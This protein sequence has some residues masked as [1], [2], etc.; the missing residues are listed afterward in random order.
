MIKIYILRYLFAFLFIFTACTGNKNAFKEID[1][2]EAIKMLLSANPDDKGFIIF[3]GKN[4]VEFV[5][6]GLEK[7]GFML[8]WPISDHN[9]ENRNEVINKV[10]SEL[11]NSGFVFK[12]NDVINRDIVINLKYHEY[13]VDST[14]LYANVG[15]NSEEIIQ[16]THNLFKTIF[17]F[18][19]TDKLKI[20]LELKG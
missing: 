8:Y 17:Q 9:R 3:T 10:S 19:N 13:V 6:Y 18:K 1:G 7:Y 15:N 11:N 4:E 20:D 12:P 5:Q 16:L 2:V 14:G